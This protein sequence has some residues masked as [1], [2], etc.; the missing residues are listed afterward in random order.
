MKKNLFLLLCSAVLLLSAG[1]PAILVRSGAPACCIIPDPAA[2]PV[3]QHAAKEL[4]VFLGKIS[5]GPAPAVAAAP[6]KGMY[7]I[8]LK[9]VKDPAIKND[10]YR[11]KVTSKGMEITA[12]QP[13]GLLYG[14]YG[15]LRES[16]GIRWLLPGDDGEYFQIRKTIS[17]PTQD[18]VVNPS[19]AIRTTFYETVNPASPMWQTSDWML[20]NGMFIENPPTLL[21]NSKLGPGLIE[22]GME[23]RGCIHGFSFLFSMDENYRPSKTKMKQM[24]D[25]NPELFPMIDGKRSYDALKN[26][27]GGDRAQPCTS[28]P[29]TVR[30]MS[31]NLCK[32]YDKYG[33]VGFNCLLGNN[34]G[35]LWCECENCR[36]LDPPDEREKHSPA[37]R[38]WTLVNQLAA[39]VYKKY[40]DADVRGWAYQNFQQ[41]PSGIV[42]DKR[43]LTELTYNRRCTRH[44]LDDPNCPIN[45]VF[46]QYFKDWRKLGQKVFTWEQINSSSHWYMPMENTY[47]NDIYTYHKL[48]TDGVRLVLQPPDGSF[49]ARLRGSVVSQTWRCMW[50]T[51]YLTASL[52]WDVNQDKDKLY[53]EINSI[54]Y[55]KAWEAGMKEFRAILNQT[56]AE[57]PGCFGH[58]LNGPVGRC[59]TK[60][61]AQQKLRAALDR[62]E[63]AVKDDPR[64]LAHVRKDRELFSKTWEAEYEKFRT[65]YRDFS[66]ILR[67]APIKID[68][69]I[70]EPD[71]KNANVIDTF[72]NARG[73]ACQPTFGRI[74]FD[75]DNLYVALEA[76][77]ENPSDMVYYSDSGKIYR[78]STLEIFLYPPELGS[79]YLH[80][81][82]NPMG[83]I[84][85]AIR[86]EGGLTVRDVPADTFEVKTAILKDRWVAECRIPAKATGMHFL[87]GSSWKINLGRNQVRKTGSSATSS[88]CNG[89]FH[90]INNFLPLLLSRARKITTNGERTISDWMNPTFA[91]VRDMNKYSTFKKWNVKNGKY[92]LNW[93][94][95]GGKPGELEVV[96]KPDGGAY[97]KFRGGIMNTCRNQEGKKFRISLKV[98]GTGKLYLRI[99]RYSTRKDGPKNKYLGNA[100]APAPIELTKEW[101]TVVREY[102]K[103]GDEEIFGLG[104][105]GDKDSE[106]WVDEVFVGVTE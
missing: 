6:A 5:G 21:Q 97:V 28:N 56:A 40:P 88:I 46:H 106:V 104:L 83:L 50:Q 17:V 8:R 47:V 98:A 99:M 94:P 54:Y 12:N 4:S 2:G 73:K 96:Q 27:S 53:E 103:P 23:S 93:H 81:I 22:R 34:D 85:G 39:A 61:G 18:H 55:G 58:G 86:Q 42:P 44:R 95:A 65:S 30:I 41:V 68:G 20:R 3:G 82:V 43:M 66:A 11:L 14:V 29:E 7:P 48:G 80:L 75:P 89:V 38:Y 10:G 26:A 15:L 62:A 64:S 91:M 45:K 24:F 1:E 57:T 37:T 19:F 84:S 67:K 87:P 70:S 49:P 100:P 35:T 13:R 105:I 78:G 25:S 51:V 36:K 52:L 77:E 32:L 31:E 72:V 102:T 63:A 74:T 69:V 79:Q 9:T 92:P 76:M 16:T 60:P 101:Q 33:I 71:W 90:G 59:L